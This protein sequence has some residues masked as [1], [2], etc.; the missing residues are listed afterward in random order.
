MSTNKQKSVYIH[1]K[2]NESYHNSDEEVANKS[3]FDLRGKSLKNTE[4]KEYEEKKQALPMK[5]VISQILQ[6]SSSQM[7]VGV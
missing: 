2:D 4:K 7:P 3:G 5:A 6:K 1:D